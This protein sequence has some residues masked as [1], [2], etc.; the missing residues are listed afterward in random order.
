MTL[1]YPQS[2]HNSVYQAFFQKRS[3]CIDSQRPEVI[4][5]TISHL[6]HVHSCTRQMR[7]S[8]KIFPID[9]M[10]QSLSCA[11]VT[12][13]ACVNRIVR[14]VLQLWQGLTRV[15]WPVVGVTFASLQKT[16]RIC[17]E[18]NFVQINA[19]A[20]KRE[21]RFTHTHTH[22][23]T[24][25]QPG[26][27]ETTNTRAYNCWIMGE[28]DACGLCSSSYLKK[29]EN[30]G[31]HDGNRGVSCSNDPDNG[32]AGFAARLSVAGGLVVMRRF[33]W[34]TKTVQAGARAKMTVN[35]QAWLRVLTGNGNSRTVVL[36][37]GVQCA[38]VSGNEVQHLLQRVRVPCAGVQDSDPKSYVRQQCLVA[39]DALNR[40]QHGLQEKRAALPNYKAINTPHFFSPTLWG[41]S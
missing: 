31:H 24:H 15:I 12:L 35:R 28:A 16:I 11:T 20:C 30:V 7:E 33:S 29:T 23:H 26:H 41:T 1:F 37:L 19:Q 25:T 40:V 36:F 21:R 6:C 2:W 18:R 4:H 3:D 39:I 13:S 8:T 22:T 34:I 9:N 27:S 17:A 10:K 38:E 5:C 14:T 32:L